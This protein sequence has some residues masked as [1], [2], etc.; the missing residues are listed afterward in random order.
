MSNKTLEIFIINKIHETEAKLKALIGK[1]DTTYNFGGK[2]GLIY[3][4]DTY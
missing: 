2:Q 1:K 3:P 4:P